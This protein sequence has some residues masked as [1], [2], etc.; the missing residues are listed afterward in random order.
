[1]VTNEQATT[2]AVRQ[3][4]TAFAERT[5]LV[6]GAPPTRYLWTDA[7]AVCTF[8]ELERRTGDGRD[9][10]LALRLVDPVQAR[11]HRTGKTTVFSD[12]RFYPSNLPE[13]PVFQS[14]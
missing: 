1:M 14:G 12:H 8:L 9:R 13:T 2:A 7:F 10:A 11:R 6:G 4:M 3:L 5:G